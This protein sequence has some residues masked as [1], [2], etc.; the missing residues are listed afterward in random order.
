[1]SD[2]GLEKLQGNAPSLRNLNVRRTSVTESGVAALKKAR[3]E[4]QIQWDGTP[5]P[6]KAKKNK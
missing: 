6:A 3:P 4:C 5:L 2:A 1:M